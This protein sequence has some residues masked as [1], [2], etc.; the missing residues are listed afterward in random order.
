MRASV[1]VQWFFPIKF[2]WYKK[3]MASLY[4]LIPVSL[5]FCALAV[6]I[7]FWAVNSGQYD[8]LDG[9][10]ER[11]LFSDD[12][13]DNSDCDEDQETGCVGMESTEKKEVEENLGNKKTAKKGSDT[14][15]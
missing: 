7:F 15:G 14:D 8:D 13:L 1:E 3:L 5:I 9:E 4:L 10:G 12:S 11:L 2:A 6:A